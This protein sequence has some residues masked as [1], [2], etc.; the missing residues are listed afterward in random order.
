VPVTIAATATYLPERWAPAPELATMT[1]IPAPVLVEKFGLTGKHVAAA[2]EHASDLACRAGQALLAE[3]DLDPASIDGLVYFGSSYKEHPVW[4]A[5]PHIAARLGAAGAF[6]LELDYVSC[7]SPVALRVAR[8][9]LAGEEHLERLLLVAGSC[10]SRIIDPANASSRFMLNF[11]DGAAAALLVRGEEPG[12]AV[13][14]SHMLTD[15]SYSRFVKMPAGGSVEPACQASVAAGRHMLD[16][17]EPAEMKRRLDAESLSRFVTAAE[18]ALKRSDA[19]LAELDYLC[20]IH[21][22]PS[23]H[24]A[25]L[26]ALG[27]EHDRAAYLADTGHMSGVDPLLALDRASRSGALNTGDLVVLLAAGTGYTWAATAVRAR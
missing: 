19:A 8:D 7:G 26:A 13:L 27:L 18:A 14:G 12:C 15:G 6:A 23:T 5:A 24:A 17:T 4:Q 9:M 16:V 25:L 22:K 20:G 10:E 3:Q 21:I 2:D 1:G 11:G